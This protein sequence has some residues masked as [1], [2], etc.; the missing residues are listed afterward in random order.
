MNKPKY[1]RHNYTEEEVEWLKENVYGVRHEELARR[2]NERFG[3]N[4]NRYNIRNMLTRRGIKNGLNQ[5]DLTKEMKQFVF[6]NYKG[7][8]NQELADRVNKEFGTNFGATKFAD[9]KWLN[10]LRSGYQYQPWLKWQKEHLHETV[11]QDGYVYI[12]V[13]N[14]W[15]AKQRWVYEQAYGELQPGE[16]IIFKDGDSTNCDL[17]N[18]I[19]VRKNVLCRVASLLTDDKEINNSLILTGLV[20]DK[21]KQIEDEGGSND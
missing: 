5:S 17:D 14:D 20:L 1:K 10:G 16:V 19:K 12:K 9:F 4:V 13:D 2:F 7:I 8:S 18:L 15:Y 6:D 21:I 3:T 11:R